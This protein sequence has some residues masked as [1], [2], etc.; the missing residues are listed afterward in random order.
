[1]P[2]K[3]LGDLYEVL[4]LLTQSCS[5]H[6]EERGRQRRGR[7]DGKRPTV[8]KRDHPRFLT[9]PRFCSS[10]ERRAWLSACAVPVEKAARGTSSYRREVGLG[11]VHSSSLSSRLGKKKGGVAPGS[12][13]GRSCGILLSKAAWSRR[14]GTLWA[15]GKGNRRKEKQGKGGGLEGCDR[16]R[17]AAR[18]PVFTG[19]IGTLPAKGK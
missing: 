1:V 19:A 8:L 13:V 7:G 18:L 15:R 12:R 2:P 17:W 5:V 11:G 4:R 9:A 14:V 10:R 16:L 6:T 3:K